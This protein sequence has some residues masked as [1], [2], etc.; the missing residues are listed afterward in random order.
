MADAKQIRDPASPEARY[1]WALIGRQTFARSQTNFA[2][3]FAEQSAI[4]VAKL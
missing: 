3:E 2:N 1:D 4:V